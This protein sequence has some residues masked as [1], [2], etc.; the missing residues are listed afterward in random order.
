MIYKDQVLEHI[1]WGA[2]RS[3]SK[4]YIALGLIEVKFIDFGVKHDYF[5]STADEIIFSI[6]DN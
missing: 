5:N 4:L 1:L 6:T 2:G 3:V